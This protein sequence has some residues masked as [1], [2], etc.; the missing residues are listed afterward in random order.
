MSFLTPNAAGEL[1][2]LR[3]YALQQLGQMRTTVY[4]LTDEQAQSTPSASELSLT[5]LLLH[6]GEVA[7]HWSARALAAPGEPVIPDGIGDH[8]L[9]ELLAD[10][11]PLDEMLADFDRCVQVTAENFDA[12]TDL[13]AL[14]PV[15][16]MPWFPQD[17]T[18]WQARWCLLH[19][20]T[21]T[22]RHVGHAD[23]IRETIDGKGSYELNDA[24]DA[25]AGA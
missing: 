5:S 6:V 18:H 25:D 3:T 4:G 9:E 23:I 7:V 22:A 17:L 24:A 2:V 21:E 16:D 19:I 1:A 11:R 15:P 14:V 8:R 10:T 20:S 12:V 13:D